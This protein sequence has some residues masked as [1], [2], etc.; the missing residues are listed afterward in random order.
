MKSNPYAFQQEAEESQ[1][2]AIV[3]FNDLAELLP[4]M[5]NSC[6]KLPHILPLLHFM[7][8]LLQSFLDISDDTNPCRVNSGGCAQL[9]T[10][11]P[12]SD[13]ATCLCYTGTLAADG[14]NCEGT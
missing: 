14:K 7:L 11:L 4:E 10:A 1:K 13:N 2:E 12:S 8:Q 3:I 6:G 5:R 9:C